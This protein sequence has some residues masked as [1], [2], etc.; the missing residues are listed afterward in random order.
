MQPLDFSVL[1]IL[2]VLNKLENIGT[3]CI[4]FQNTNKLDKVWVLYSSCWNKENGEVE[5]TCQNLMRVFSEFLFYFKKLEEVQQRP[6]SKANKDWSEDQWK[7]VLWSDASKYYLDCG[8]ISLAS[9]QSCQVPSQALVEL[10]SFP[11][12]KKNFSSDFWQ[13]L[14]A[15]IIVF[16]L[17]RLFTFL[18]SLNTTSWCVLIPPSVFVTLC[19]R[20]LYFPVIFEW[21]D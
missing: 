9:R 16:D 2:S 14:S 8:R 17:S 7:N 21:R 10:L 15:P 1:A 3:V 6:A 18:Y 12:S 19:T 5:E 13:L 20:F 4:V 11:Q